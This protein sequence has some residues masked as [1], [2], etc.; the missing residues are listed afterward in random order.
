M[1]KLL[2]IGDT[3][4]LY[5]HNYASRLRA[6]FGQSRI[7]DIFATF[8]PKRKSGG[9]P[10][11][12]VYGQAEA[13]A[14]RLLRP[15]KLCAFLKE[16]KE[17]YDAVHVLYCIQD[18]MLSGGPLRK[19]APRLILTVF[20]SDFFQLSSIKLK[21]FGKVF[22]SADRI[23]SN[24]SQALEKIGSAFSADPA[25]LELCRFGFNALDTL[26]GMRGVP[27]WASR[28]KL[29][30]PNDRIV[31]CIGYNYDSIQQHI[32][33][34]RSLGSTPGLLQR[35]EDLFFLVPMT[36]GTEPAY[37]AELLQALSVF[38]YK[39]RALEDF[40]SEE[41]NAHLRK[42]PD[43]ML[44]LQKNDSFSASTQEH[45]YGENLLI[46]GNWLP[47]GDLLEAGVY[48]RTTASPEASG[49]ELLSC[50]LNLQAEKD[51]CLLNPEKVYKL[52]SWE[53]NFPSWLRLYE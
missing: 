26:Q 24:N 41:D 30:I 5:V 43:I 19:V 22:R 48:F 10:Y 12:H 27:Q 9:M 42:A 52:S 17:T 23:T 14:K 16:H 2:L 11:D 49:E 25:R 29:G 6:H 28:E 33:V 37:K 53:S 15:L 31:V 44:Q 32:P 4:S 3:N 7:I 39:Y 20:G 18:L 34:L 36:Y 1:R 13:G 21:L 45:L 8:S 40:L 51:K 46:T 50:L 47:Y 38:P 35:K